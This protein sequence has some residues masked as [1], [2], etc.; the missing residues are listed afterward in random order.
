MLVARQF[1]INGRVQGVGYRYFAVRV[2]TACGVVGTVRNLADGSV[3]V[4]AEGKAA[5][6]ADFR[7]QLERGPALSRVTWIDE[8]E[9]DATGRYKTFDVE[10]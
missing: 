3:E 7:K 5:A 8:V 6:V 4:I 1:R 2:A 10:F 9:L